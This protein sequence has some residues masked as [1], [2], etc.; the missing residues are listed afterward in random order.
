M[1]VTQKASGHEDTLATALAVTIGRLRTQSGHTGIACT[2]ELSSRWREQI[3]ESLEAGR[4]IT[5][6]GRG[7]VQLSFGLDL[8]A[9]PPLLTEGDDLTLQIDWQDGDHWRN[10]QRWY[11]DT[12]DRWY[13]HL[14]L[15]LAGDRVVSTASNY[16]FGDT[17]RPDWL[18][19][20][21][22]D[23]WYTQ[24]LVV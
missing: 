1:T 9:R 15:S 6:P 19:T 14:V 20:R 5:N 24:R 18:I 21:L 12:G 11:T 2:P 16:E 22:L 4:A 3:R 17:S 23:R 8:D 10:D 7:S 13:V